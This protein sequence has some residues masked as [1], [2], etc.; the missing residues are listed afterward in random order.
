MAMQRS[1][2]KGLRSRSPDHRQ[3]EILLSYY[4][5]CMLTE[6]EHLATLLTR[7]FPQHPFAWKV[8]GAVFSRSGRLNESLVPKK[9]C[10]ELC[11]QDA[12]AHNNLGNTFHELGKLEDAE[13]SLRKAIALNPNYPE[14]YSNLG[15]TLLGLGRLKE[16]EASNR[17]AI[18]LRPDLFTAHYNLGNT[19]QKLGKLHLAEESY[20]ETIA[21]KRGFGAAHNNLGNIYRELGRL[22]AAEASYR[23]ATLLQPDD[24]EAQNNLGVTL[25]ALGRLDEARASYIQAINLEPDF[26]VAHHNLSIT[27][28]ELGR[29]D[30]AELSCR[31]VIALDSTFPDAHN[32][33][34]KTLYLAEKHSLFFDELDNLTSRGEISS[35]IGSLTC[36]AA[37]KYGVEKPNLFCSK[38]LDH[39][40]HVDL[41]NRQDFLKT[42]VE[43]AISIFDKKETGSRHQPLLQNGQQ[44]SGNLFDIE[45]SL[46]R[47]LQKAIR[48]E[49]EKYRDHFKHSKEGFIKNWPTKYSL[50]GWLIRM[51]SGGSLKPHIHEAGWISGSIYINVPERLRVGEGSLALSPGEQKDVGSESELVHEII[52]VATGSLVLFPASMTHYTLPFESIHQRVVLAFD[53]VP[54]LG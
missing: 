12:E 11:P 25:H 48:S 21:L 40:L 7:E 47:K 4:Q 49:V 16:S 5:S 52:D 37:L 24:A 35:I 2:N 30:E 14:A 50:F 33:L 27:L 15:N 32:R 3:L 13:A 34:L 1:N 10:V 45:E 31:R 53:V 9:K 51:D 41:K 36:R 19:L 44:T 39:V 17:K 54:D 20:L 43:P 18:G 29:F 28:H 23:Q 42:F 26:I 46:T 6:A 8:L 22:D 38:P